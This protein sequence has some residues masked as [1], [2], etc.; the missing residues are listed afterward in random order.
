MIDRQQLLKDLQRLLPKIEQDILAYAESKSEL[1]TH[2]R[3]EY[4]K[5]KEANRTAEHFVAWREA[6]ITQAAVAWIL[7]CVFIRFLEDNELLD[8]PMIAGPAGPRLQH[9]K[10]RLTV[11]FNE[12][13]EHAEREYLLSLF[14]A[15]E[16]L[17]VMAELLDHRHN[18]L[19][20]LPV[21]A[22]GARGLIDF[23]QQLN[24]ESGEVVHDFTDANW[25][26]RFL[27]DLYQDLSESVRKRYALLQTPEFVESFILDY[28]LEK[29]KETF[30]L[31][32]L[33]LID[34]TCGSGHFL[35]TSF[36]RLF[37]DWIRREPT[38]N[39]RALAQRALD[40]V[41][42][43]DINPYAIAVARFRL[44]IA[45]MKAAGSHKLKDA[46]DFHFNLAV[47]DSL[48]HGQ[49]HESQGQGIQP[50]LMDDS[51][52]HV[53]EVED[54]EK[55]EQILGRQRYHV[56][57]G[58]PP[59]ITVKDKALNQAYRD[60]YPTCHRQYSLGVPFTERFFDLT[61]PAEENHPA[62][63]MGMI[64][65]NS[66][67]KRE[68]GKKLIESYL[69][70]KE[71]THV[72]DT[73]GAYI[74]GHGTPTVILFARNQK[75]RMEQLRAVLGIRGEPSTPADAAQGKVWCSIVEMLEKPGSENDFIS[76]VNQERGLYG[77]H[78]WSVGGGGAAEL[79]EL[80]E[81]NGVMGLGGKITEIGRTT[82]TGEDAIFYMP[83]NSIA[84]R[85][86]IDNS[87]PLVVGEQ[88]RDWEIT[89][90][91]WTLMPYDLKTGDTLSTLPDAIGQ[92][93][94][95]FRRLLRNRSDF[96]QFIEERGLKWFEHSMFFP[97]RYRTP[98]SIT[99]A[100]VAPHNHFVLDRGGKVFNRSAPVI[101]LP[102]DATEADHL[103]LLGLLN[104]STACFWMKQVSQQKQLTGGDGVR[105]EFISKV[106]YEFAGSQ[107]KKM[108][109]PEAFFDPPTRNRILDLAKQCDALAS[110][111]K[112]HSA[113]KTIDNALASE[114]SIQEVWDAA[115]ATRKLIRSKMILLQEELDWVLYSAY[116]LCGDDLTA[117][118]QP[119]MDTLIDAGQRPFEIIAGFNQDGF[120]VPKA[121][122]DYWP[123]SMQAKW[124]QRIDAIR[125]N[126]ELK[127]IEDPHYKR[128][129]IG[130]QGLFN[131]AARANELKDAC[132]DWLLDHL[133]A[134]CQTTELLTCAQLAERIR[135]DPAFQ[136]VAALYAGSDTFDAQLLV[137]E[138]L[139]GDNVPQ[140]AAARY[141][142]KAMPKFRAWQETWEKQRAEDAIDARTELDKADP[143]YLSKEEATALKT[144]Q[145]G[146]I[147]LPPKYAVS[148]FRRPSYWPLRGK[149]DVPKERFFSMPLCEKAGDNTLV[150]GWAGLNHL[151][152]A[153]AIAAWYLDRKEHEG[154]D[155]ERLKPLLVALDELAPW[156]KQWHN[157]ID[158]EFG[159]RL[160]DYYEGFL[161][162]E[163]RQ[164]D[165]SRDDLT[166]WEPPAATRGG[167]RRRK[168]S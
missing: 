14:E 92:H 83:R 38:T 5:A 79:K 100:F 126:H 145:I 19:W 120:V 85:C 159:E 12:Y 112:T 106:P 60:K 122:P 123:V 18:P 98:L 101:K 1:D 142:P 113:H 134:R 2:L 64:T 127:I 43:V 58:N 17:P 166:A 149:L 78:P 165:I 90:G 88:I 140:M 84:T 164:L 117:G 32:G 9:A 102:A 65:T 148:D 50:D 135:N 86:L 97:S 10:D 168:T 163:L 162:E 82:H 139:A 105:V 47:G 33:R 136:Q 87:V 89:P 11:H 27:G 20:Q 69:P 156:L 52:S 91:E 48:L 124:Q 107:L 51:L 108:P 63:Y 56:V 147:P 28:T 35:L 13:P 93:F 132:K 36:E 155:A 138:L 40:S 15:L 70:R 133:E 45:A 131:H 115:L 73:S 137:S 160:G 94:W 114:N 76:V 59:Y 54:R 62:G 110:Q 118:I 3:Q 30:G 61:L 66:F 150:I 95:S 128:R 7:T 161:L 42:G 96:G 4:T 129:W 71:L 99:F 74:P 141:K 24:P 25:D 143:H 130:R 75:P 152:R 57:V 153:Q 103:A 167:G 121:I 111:S 6:Q 72:I 29:A 77:R 44:L 125:S 146:D 23:F 16:Q 39:A 116:G 81:C 8:E 22:D 49:R 53:F 21:S 119:W 109:I 34:P 41:Y 157:E 80:L 31:P 144:K 158:P 55:L 67:M 68:F 37:N 104:S 154:W 26:T 151:Q 46:P